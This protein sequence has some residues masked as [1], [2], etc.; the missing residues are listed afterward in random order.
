MTIHVCCEH[1]G[2]I[3]L[4]CQNILQKLKN[5]LLSI[6]FPSGGEN[7]VAIDLIVLHV[8][9]QLQKVCTTFIVLI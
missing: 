4:A 1:L 2:C 7:H 8:H 3:S 9:T 5:N 6:F